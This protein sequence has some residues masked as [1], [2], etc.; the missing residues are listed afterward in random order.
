LRSVRGVVPATDVG[1]G[2]P[3]LDDCPGVLEPDRAPA[4][5]TARSARGIG[6][7]VEAQAVGGD[8]E[9]AVAVRGPEQHLGFTKGG[10]PVCGQRDA[11]YRAVLQARQQEGRRG[12]K[13]AIS[14]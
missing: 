7:N 4:V 9:I 2:V 8:G 12:S 5:R 1:I 10:A 14:R 11:V 6:G 13:H 3:E